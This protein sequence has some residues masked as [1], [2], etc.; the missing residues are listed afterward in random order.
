[1]LHGRIRLMIRLLDLRRVRGSILGAMVKQRIRQ[2]AAD[3]FV[4]QNE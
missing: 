1:M 4:E 3:P 2:G